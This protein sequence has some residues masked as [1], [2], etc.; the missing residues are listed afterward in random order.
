MKLIP[1]LVAVGFVGSIAA[2][3]IASWD[4]ARGR[5]PD[6]SSP[7]IVALL[8][9]PEARTCTRDGS[10]AVAAHLKPGMPREEA[11]ATLRQATVSAPSPWFW[12]PRSEDSLTEQPGRIDFVRVMRYTAFGNHRVSGSVLL[13]DG[14][15]AEV[16]ARIACAFG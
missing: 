12:T 11:L 8:T 7:L 3:A 13:Q 14:A 9:A 10:A 2:L 4:V 6:T 1:R 5:A 15:V 16:K